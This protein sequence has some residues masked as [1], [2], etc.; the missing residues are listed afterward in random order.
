MDPSGN[1][2]FQVRL[3]HDRAES[4]CNWLVSQGGVSMGRLRTTGSEAGPS[5]SDSSPDE[6]ED[7]HVRFHVL[8]EVQIRDKLEFSGSSATLR[9][10]SISTL[11]QVAAILLENRDLGKVMIEGHS[12]TDGPADW[13]KALSRERA[14]SVLECLTNAGVEESRLLPFG[15]GYEKPLHSNDTRQGRHS[16]RRVEFLVVP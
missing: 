9:P 16:N 4:V 15:Y 10:A 11:Q 13:N 5:S 6:K 1:M 12:C 3:A 7:W 2:D 8:Q 14:D